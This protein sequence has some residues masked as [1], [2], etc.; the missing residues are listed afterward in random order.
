MSGSSTSSEEP[1]LRRSSRKVSPV[2]YL[3][4]ITR[5][6]GVENVWPQRNATKAGDPRRTKK[7]EPVR[8]RVEKNES[9]RKKRKSATVSV[10]AEQPEKENPRYQYVPVYQEEREQE[11]MM[12]DNDAAPKTGYIPHSAFLRLNG[13][14][15]S[16]P[17]ITIKEE[18]VERPSDSNVTVGIEEENV[19]PGSFDADVIEIEQ[20]KIPHR[21][22]IMPHKLMNGIKM[23]P[24]TN[25]F[26]QL[27]MKHESMNKGQQHQLVPAHEPVHI[28]EEPRIE[29]IAPRIP[30]YRSWTVSCCYETLTLLY[31]NRFILS[32]IQSCNLAQ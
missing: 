29:H 8:R 3:E 22:V 11:N 6:V 2:C 16:I 31:I 32:G 20:E 12:V 4:T 7:K 25:L 14:P 26:P 21:P 17:V 30:E 28:K 27:V 23:E 18:V 9:R 15:Y 24:P 19:A 5:I 13:Q 1:K 10:A